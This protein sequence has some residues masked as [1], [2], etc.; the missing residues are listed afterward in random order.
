MA[1]ADANKA[2]IKHEFK[3]DFVYFIGVL[4]LTEVAS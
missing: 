3:I 4:C 2:P 1:M